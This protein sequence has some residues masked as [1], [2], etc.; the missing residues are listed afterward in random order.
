MW[1]VIRENRNVYC[2]VFF[3]EVI[4]DNLFNVF[5]SPPSNS[6]IVS[7]NHPDKCQHSKFVSN[8]DSF[9]YYTTLK[10]KITIYF[11][12]TIYNSK[13]LVYFEKI[14]LH[15]FKINLYY[16]WKIF[17][18][19]INSVCIVDGNIKLMCPPAWNVFA[20]RFV[21]YVTLVSPLN[22]IYRGQMRTT[23]TKPS[24]PRIMHMW[25]KT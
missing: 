18:L 14:K 8:N 20:Y 15:Y 3:T 11:C 23:V 24:Q 4:I 5:N 9:N 19:T 7:P 6:V 13:W 10:N 16:C 25:E 17:Q 22:C 1:F 21:K 2:W 12:N